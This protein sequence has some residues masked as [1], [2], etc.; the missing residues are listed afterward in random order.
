M[1]LAIPYFH[2]FI[3]HFL[4]C[5]TIWPRDTDNLTAGQA[6]LP[7]LT[8]VC[9]AKWQEIAFVARIALCAKFLAG[10]GEMLQL[11]YFGQK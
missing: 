6:K 5:S 4:C 2:G 10:A 7:C 8:R 3:T 9:T 1:P 11:H